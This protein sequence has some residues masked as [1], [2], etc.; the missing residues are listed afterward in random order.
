MKAKFNDGLDKTLPILTE[1]SAK[2]IDALFMR[3]SVLEGSMPTFTKQKHK[4]GLQRSKTESGV[5]NLFV[6]CDANKNF[7]KDGDG[8]TRY[9]GLGF[10][11]YPIRD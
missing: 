7:E 10:K 1:V 8:S 6:F 2:S 4:C 5:I 11:L 3:A 9:K